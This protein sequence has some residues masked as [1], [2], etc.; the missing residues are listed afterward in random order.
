MMP[1]PCKGLTHK[2]QGHAKTRHGK[3]NKLIYIYLI[4][5]A[6][7]IPLSV[8]LPIFV[9]IATKAV[10]AYKYFFSY[11]EAIETSGSSNIL[12]YTCYIDNSAS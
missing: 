4:N 1:S 8:I 9:C 6:D 7:P 2:S 10:K 3:T 11:A 12:F 5:T